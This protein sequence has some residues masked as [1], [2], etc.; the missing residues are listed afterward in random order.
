MEGWGP[1]GLRRCFLWRALRFWGFG[2][3]GFGDASGEE[4]FGGEGERSE[5]VAGEPEDAG[6]DVGWEGSGIEEGGDGFGGEG[7]GGG[8]GDD[9][10]GG[11]GATEG[12]G[13]E[14]AGKEGEVGVVGEGGGA[15]AEDFGGEDLV[16]HGDIIA[17]LGWGSGFWGDLRSGGEVL[18]LKMGKM[19]DLRSGGWWRRLG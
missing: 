2:A 14:M 18:F 4:E 10:G 5:V 9:D 16:E 8:G 15:L 12:D 13:D 17:G 3:A 6:R 7:D 19:G 11:G 1:E